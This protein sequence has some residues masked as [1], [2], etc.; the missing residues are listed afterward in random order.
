MFF[1]KKVL[2]SRCHTK[3]RVWQRLR[4]LGAF[5]RNAAQ[6]ELF[7]HVYGVFYDQPVS[8]DQSILFM[9][10]VHIPTQVY[11][12]AYLIFFLIFWLASLRLLLCSSIIQH[13]YLPI[14]FYFKFVPYRS[15]NHGNFTQIETSF[16]IRNSLNFYMDCL[17]EIDGCHINAKAIKLGHKY[18]LVN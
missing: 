6:T 12:V 11:N 8:L 1:R 16:F 17:F 14:W 18:G 13:I 10:M 7:F 9:G 15:G 2:K 4:T 3:R 5:S